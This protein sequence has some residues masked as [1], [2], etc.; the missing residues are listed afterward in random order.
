MIGSDPE[1]TGTACTKVAETNA[2]VAVGSGNLPL[3]ATPMLIALMENAACN[4][5]ANQLD[6]GQTTVGTHIEVSHT[7]PS[8]L[9]AEIT[10][11]ARLVS[12]DGHRLSFHLS[13][14]DNAGQIGEGAH[15]RVIVD[16]ERL[17]TRATAR[18]PSGQES[19][20][21]P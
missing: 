18:V 15:I 19:P 5:I 14:Y 21:R 4:A 6:P 17:L 1:I 3:F 2:A 12:V 20:S 16:S 11:T 8:P 9:G 10:A 13:A 7:A